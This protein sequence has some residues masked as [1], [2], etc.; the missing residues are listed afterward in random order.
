MVYLVSLYNLNGKLNC[1]IVL[2]EIFGDGI[3]KV[4][5]FLN[6]FSF[7]V[8]LFFIILILYIVILVI[9]KKCKL[10]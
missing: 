7:F 2:D 10:L 1:Y 9:L 6:F 8:I 5:Y 4:Y 3:K